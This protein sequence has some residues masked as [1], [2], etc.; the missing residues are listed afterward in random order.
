MT[1]H[2][3]RV[4]ETAED[5]NHFSKLS[6][7][8]GSMLRQITWGWLFFLFCFK[9]CSNIPLMATQ[10]KFSSS[11]KSLCRISSYKHDLGQG[12]YFPDYIK[13]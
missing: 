12:K 1:Q 11:F 8:N 7:K 2:L 13:K 3:E 9:Y 6:Q 10:K 5:L 4:Q